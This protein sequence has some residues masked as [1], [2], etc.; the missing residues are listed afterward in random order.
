MGNATVTWQMK[1]FPDSLALD[2]IFLTTRLNWNISNF[3]RNGI[4]FLEFTSCDLDVYIQFTILSPLALFFSLQTKFSL[5][6]DLTDLIYTALSYILRQREIKQIK[7]P[8]THIPRQRNRKQGKLLPYFSKLFMCQRFYN[9]FHFY[10]LICTASK[11]SLIYHLVK[12][13]TAS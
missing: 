6:R 1:G 13:Q 8:H 9:G 3:T 12:T 7:P 2:L 4:K 11:I 5:G 10:Q